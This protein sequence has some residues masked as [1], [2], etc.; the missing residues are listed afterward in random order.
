[1]IPFVLA[2]SFLTG[3]ISFSVLE[4]VTRENNYQAYLAAAANST[5]KAEEFENYKHSIRLNPAREEAYLTLL[6]N[7]FLDDGIFTIE[8]SE[9]LRTILI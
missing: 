9:T 8:E 1:M 3:L 4:K 2:I 6:H 5:T 7:M